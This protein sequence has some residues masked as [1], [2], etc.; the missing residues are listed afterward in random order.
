MKDKVVVV[1]GGSRGI[2]AG[3][4]ELFYREGA[5][6]VVNYRSDDDAAHALK[7]KLSANDDRLKLLR[8]DVSQTEGRKH[9]LERTLQAF[10]KIDVLVNNAG[11]AA[12]QGFLNGTEEEFDRI[13]ETNLKG[14]VFLAQDCANHMIEKNIKGSIINLCS[15]SAH[16][17]NAP[18]SYCAA[19]AGLLMATKTMALAL[20]RYGIRVNNVT[21]GTIKSDMNRPYWQDMPDKWQQATQNLPLGRGGE[22]LEL[23]SAVLYLAD[24]KSSFVTGTEIIV[25]GGFCLRP[26]WQ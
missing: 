22:A 17:A 2:G 21:P 24:D 7:Q 9:L 11:I 3:I 13:I 10:E 25:D 15:V 26:F 20:G 19:K 23:A 14:P 18:T 12:R 1:T 16:F 6:V 5:K 8:A 4:S